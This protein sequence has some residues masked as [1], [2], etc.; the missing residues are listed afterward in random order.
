MHGILMKLTI[1]VV[2]WSWVSQPLFSLNGSETCGHYLDLGGSL[3]FVP[4]EYL[5][6]S[7]SVDGN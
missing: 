7:D 5:L 2:I 1:F 6:C 4:P 3:C